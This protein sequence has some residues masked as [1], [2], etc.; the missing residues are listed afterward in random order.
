V[1]QEGVG[2]PGREDPGSDNQSPGPPQD[3]H[4]LRGKVTYLVYL[5]EGVENTWQK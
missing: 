3:C 5:N 2:G 1:L 4:G